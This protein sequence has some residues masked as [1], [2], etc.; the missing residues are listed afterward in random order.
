[1]ELVDWNEMYSQ[2]SAQAMPILSC[3]YGV[4]FIISTCIFIFRGKSRD[5]EFLIKM[6]IMQGRGRGGGDDKTIIIILLLYYLFI[7]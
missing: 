5:T 1:M 7:P 3:V 6:L 4:P 2:I